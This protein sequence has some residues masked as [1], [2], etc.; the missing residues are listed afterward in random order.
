LKFF[1][2]EMEEPSHESARGG[3]CHAHENAIFERTASEA[4]RKLRG[5]E[6]KRSIA[7]RITVWIDRRVTSRVSEIELDCRGRG[8]G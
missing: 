3:L 7:S 2:R 1:S 5:H 6:V 8:R 4:R